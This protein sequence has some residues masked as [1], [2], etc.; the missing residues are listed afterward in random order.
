VDND[1]LYQ[2][3]KEGWIAAAGIDDTAEEPAKKIDW[4]PDNPLFQLDNIIITPHSA[5]Y[6]EESIEEARRCVSEEVARVLNGNPPLSPV[7]QVK[8]VDGS[9]SMAS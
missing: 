1:A 4:K 3:L 6:S 2:A 5:Y 9:Y 8:L 7:N